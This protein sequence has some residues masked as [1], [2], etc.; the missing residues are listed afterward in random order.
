MYHIWKIMSIATN[1]LC[2]P[3]IFTY[4][5]TRDMFLDDFNRRLNLTMFYVTITFVMFS[6]AQAMIITNSIK[7]AYKLYINYNNIGSEKI[8]S[9]CVKSR[10]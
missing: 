1:I 4:I 5:Q 3:I 6:L 10:F 9:L 7:N 8:E 2:T